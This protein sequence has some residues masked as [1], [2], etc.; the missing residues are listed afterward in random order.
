MSIRIIDWDDCY[1]LGDKIDD[2][3]YDRIQG[4]LRYPHLPTRNAVEDYHHVFWEMI[5]NQLTV[6]DVDVEP[7]AKVPRREDK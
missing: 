1:L 2:H 6:T 4:D 3:H 5:V 7:A